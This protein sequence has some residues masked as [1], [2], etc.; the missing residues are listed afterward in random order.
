MGPTS[1]GAVPLRRGIDWLDGW[2]RRS[3]IA[4]IGPL[5]GADGA[6]YPLRAAG[7]VRLERLLLVGPEAA[8]HRR[9]RGADLKVVGRGGIGRHARHLLLARE[10]AVLRRVAR[11]VREQREG[12]LRVALVG[13]VVVSPLRV[14]LAPGLVG[15]RRVAH[16]GVQD[17]LRC[18]RPL[19]A[20]DAIGVH[21]VRD[22]RD[23]ARV[24]RRLAQLGPRALLALVEDQ[25][26]ASR[27]RRHQLRGLLVQGLDA[28]R[29]TRR[30]HRKE[31]GRVLVFHGRLI[32]LALHPVEL[33]P[34]W[35]RRV[36]AVWAEGERAARLRLIACCKVGQ[37]R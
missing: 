24:V 15:Q 18:E 22:A 19:E 9:R 28:A 11:V 2:K 36:L 26:L 10:D 12:E 31:V 7:V 5:L 30:R 8:P 25:R 21:G 4:S 35:A 33:P 27:C 1:V 23:A 14:L 17:G 6:M 20:Q 16:V 37:H 3:E 13:Q 34:V 29:A 32:I